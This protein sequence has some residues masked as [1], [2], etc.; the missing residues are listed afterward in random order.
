MHWNPTHEV[1]RQ[2]AP[3]TGLLRLPPRTVLAAICVLVL[4]ACDGVGD[5]DVAETVDA[6][7]STDASEYRDEGERIAFV[8]PPDG[9]PDTVWGTDVYTTDSSVCTAAVH[10]GLITF[11]EGGD[12]VIEIRPGEDEY[13]S[14]ERNGVRSRGWEQWGVSF[15]F[16]AA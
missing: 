14:S 12:V 13:E 16:P 8:C 2:R 5:D 9:E 15:V 3:F 6:T 10:A 4:A 7:W 1:A 11:D